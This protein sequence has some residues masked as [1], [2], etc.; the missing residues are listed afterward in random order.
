MFKPKCLIAFV[1]VCLGSLQ[2]HAELRLEG[3]YVRGLPPTQTVT[4][5]FMDIVND[6]AKPI[7]IVAASTDIAERVEIHKH[8]HS[9][10]MMRMEQVQSVEV[11]ANDRFVFKPM[12]YH[13][14]LFGLKR[15]LADGEE[16]SLE[17][18]SADGQSIKQMVPVKSVL[19]E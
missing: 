10:G 16:V 17:V 18:V 5:A 2:A 11:P 3:A 8:S 12:G 19:K 6:S 9:G 13:L 15:P 1:L 14:M 4:A 7:T